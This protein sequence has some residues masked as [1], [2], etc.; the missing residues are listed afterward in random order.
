MKKNILKITALC[1][2]VLLAAGG[3]AT[4][5]FALSSDGNEAEKQEEAE[6]QNE[7]E[8]QEEPE[9]IAVGDTGESSNEADVSSDKTGVSGDETGVSKDETVYVLAGAD[10]SVQKIIV[11]D[12]LKNSLGNAAVS[13]ESELTNVENVEGDETYTMSG[14][15]M[16]VW[17]ARGNDIY[18]QGSIEKELPVTLSV[19]YKLDGNPI[20]ADDL[21]G[22]SGRVTI[23]F[24]YQNKQ[25]ETVEIDG[26]Q[27]KIYVPFA[28]LTGFL[29]DDDIF[30]N[31]DV[32]NGKLINDGG[33]TA[34]IGIAFPGLQENLAL[35]KDK[36]EIPDYVEI[37]A[38]VSCFQ[39][40]MTVTLATNELFSKLDTN[41]F[42]SIS[43]LR[44]SMDELTDA[45]GKLLDG[46]SQ[47]YDGLVTL[48]EKSDELVEGI[49]QLTSGAESL[50]NGAG[51]LDAGAAEL[52]AGAAQLSNGLNALA[53]NNGTLNAGAGQVFNTLLS[54]ANTQ[55]AAAGLDVPA[56]TV[57]NYGQVLSN[58]IA[59]LDENAVYG[60]AQSQVT[61]AV[62]AQRGTI[63]QQVKAAV[64]Q[65]VTPQV[66]A[67]VR[68]EVAAQ[69][70]QTVR[71]TVA[72]QVIQSVQHMDKASYDAAVGA[73]QIDQ[74]TQEKIE[75]AIEQQMQSEQV[76]SQIQ[77]E[78]DTQMATQPIQDTIAAK[79]S[80]QMQNDTIQQTIAEQ[81]QLQIQKIISEQ[82]AS[83]EVQAQ[84][85]AAA[86]GA[87][88]VIA[89]KSS[90]DSYN[91]FYL[92]LQS[93]TAG[94]ADAAAGAGTLRAGT[95]DLKA[96]TS[97]LSAGASKLYD[98]ILTLKKGTPALVDGITQ[99]RD[100]AMQLSEG[101]KEFNEEGIKKLVDAVDG[102]LD[103][104]MTRFRATRDVSL[105][106]KN[107]AG[108]SEDMD[109]Q[110]K[111]I[112][113]TD[114]IE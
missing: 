80:E 41:S 99:L 74:G 14:D 84:L 62:E 8:K 93:Y 67:A 22:K 56:L 30:T 1:L 63:E 71:G 111:F 85:A 70:T 26:R 9:T 72:E 31:V 52:E 110:V 68:E 38:D 102:D 112:Y 10:G 98:G 107:F 15:N 20:T 17:D 50:K 27:E 105:R 4:T 7:S 16:L 28:M 58:V 29:L 83:D 48:L 106:Y 24:D 46:S 104:L 35:S 82:M 13:D 60:Q 3:I 77:A 103:G 89:L 51:S 59:S 39:L 33:R 42:D 73:G 92:G 96:G 11:S 34:V 55:L 37:T 87:K 64:Q 54:T 6:K 61:A 40:D 57:E 36:L 95:D 69:V 25:Y 94:V 100:G 79:V 2:C 23:R 43:E 45:M 86:E 114:A 66:T 44:A 109:G 108:A 5:A 90:L 88:S 113:R 53:A 78:T 75:A 49:D 19:S 47:L 12:W 76:L 32:T 81:T 21:V 18:Y 97:Q 65:E 91:A 101:L